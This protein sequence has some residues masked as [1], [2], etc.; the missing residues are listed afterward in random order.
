MLK[1][2]EEIVESFDKTFLTDGGT[3]LG[4]RNPENV[5]HFL[6]QAL[7]TRDEEYRSMIV[8]MFKS[9]HKNKE[10]IHTMECTGCMEVI[11][12]NKVLTDILSALPNQ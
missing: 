3:N 7:A 11:A 6:R 12:H 8:G 5:R 9:A 10:G 4:Y 1:P 2:I